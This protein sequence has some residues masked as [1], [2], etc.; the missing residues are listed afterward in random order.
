[1]A[2]LLHCQDNGID[3]SKALF[4]QVG[5]LGPKYV[6]WVHSPVNRPL[7]FFES[8]LMESLS[9]SPWW[10]VPLI[11]IPI[12]L[13]ICYL[14]LTGSPSWITFLRSA[15]P[16]SVMTL[17]IL[18]PFGVLFWTFLEYSLHRFVFHLDPPPTSRA[19]ITFHFILH[20]QHHKVSHEYSYK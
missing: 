16:L 20:G 12:I 18:L 10:L 4:G 17:L 19:W 13:Y 8:D 14:A 7:R 6:K 5:K 15:P 9:K 2:S 3:W 11:W 1:M